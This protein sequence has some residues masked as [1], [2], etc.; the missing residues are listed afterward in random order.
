[1]PCLVTA[2]P[3]LIAQPAKY[4]HKTPLIAYQKQHEAMQRDEAEADDRI[5]EGLEQI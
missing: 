4:V 2:S 3:L 5:E 1:M